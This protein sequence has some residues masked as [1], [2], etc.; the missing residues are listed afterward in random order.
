MR[1]R[2][3]CRRQ[4][5]QVGHRPSPAATKTRHIITSRRIPQSLQTPTT[6]CPLSIVSQR[7]PG[8]SRPPLSHESSAHLK[9]EHAI[10]LDCGRSPILCHLLEMRFFLGI[11]FPE[12]AAASRERA[13]AGVLVSPKS[14]KGGPRFALPSTFSS[15]VPH[16]TISSTTTTSSLLLPL[17]D[18][19]LFT[20]TT[21]S[22]LLPLLDYYL[23]ATTTSS[24][25]LPLLDYY[26]F[27]TTTSSRLLPLLDYYLSVAHVLLLWPTA[28][29]NTRST[30]ATASPAPKIKIRYTASPAPKINVRYTAPHPR[31]RS[32]VPLRQ[33]PRSRS[34]TRFASTQDQGSSSSAMTLNYHPSSTVPLRQPLPLPPFIDGTASSAHKIKVRHRPQ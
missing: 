13:V 16:T 32:A 2:H 4:Q 15:S 27:A 14:I 25:L 29:Y 8:T 20:T 5:A 30:S 11:S 1:R 19:Y 34:T 12:G 6:R 9:C 10:P 17:L 26:L 18:Y 3:P 31:S 33:H 28:D 23:F 24:R 22:R 7:T 21:S